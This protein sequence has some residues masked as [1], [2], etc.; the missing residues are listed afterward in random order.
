MAAIHVPILDQVGI[1]AR[2]RRMAYQIYEANFLEAELI[3]I[4]I[5]QRGGFLARE[6][7]AY[8][9]QICPIPLTLVQSQLDRVSDSESLGIDLSIDI[10]DMKGKPLVVVD[11]VLY[12]GRT[13]LNVVAILLQAQ[14]KSIQTAILIDRGHRS[15][16][17]AADFVGLELATTLHQQVTVEIDEPAG[18]I[19][20]YLS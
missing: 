7:V 15:L 10:E 11:D 19:Q 5:D 8:L 3:L 20:A 16:P 4:G 14:P 1:Y 6:L 13:L 18:R 2:L 17:V 9:E 12:T